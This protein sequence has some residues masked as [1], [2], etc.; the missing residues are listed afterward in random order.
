[1]AKLLDPLKRRLVL[2]GKDTA[3][4]TLIYYG[5]L[6]LQEGRLN[7]AV[8]F[9]G[10]AGHREGLLRIKEWALQNGDAFLL[11]QVEVFLGEEIPEGVWVE[12]GKKAK[13]LGKYAFAQKAFARA[14]DMEALRE[15]QEIMEREGRSGTE[16]TGQ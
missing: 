2:Y 16:G 5:D 14:R 11:E 9:Y 15:V 12:L 6:Y 13:E 7:D 3:R 10:R 4:E 8:E 1:M